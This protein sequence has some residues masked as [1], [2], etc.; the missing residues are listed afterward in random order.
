VGSFRIPIMAP[1]GLESVFVSMPDPVKSFAREGFALLSELNES[2]FSTF[3]SLI[4]EEIG[5]PAQPELEALREKLGLNTRKAGTLS[6]I[7]AFATVVVT[8]GESSEKAVQAAEGAGVLPAGSAAAFDRL[9]QELRPQEAAFRESIKSSELASEILPSFD[10]IDT[11]V[12][13]RLGF[14]R[15]KVSASIPI[16]VAH[17]K[18]DARESHVWF[19]MQKR[20]IVR[21]ISQFEKLLKQLEEAERWAAR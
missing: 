17:L 6:M 21:L 8:S 20:D 19:Q 5:S 18:T 14:D 4:K 9:V 2:R 1:D 11:T 3:V 13:L 12:D 7:A 16:I 15:E 10:E